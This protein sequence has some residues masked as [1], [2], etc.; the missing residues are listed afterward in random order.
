MRSNVK[1]ILKVLIFLI[2]LGSVV[3]LSSKEDIS[4]KGAQEGVKMLKLNIDPNYFDNSEIWSGSVSGDGW[5]SA[6]I[7]EGS[8]SAPTKEIAL[9]SDRYRQE[10]SGLGPIRGNDEIYIMEDGMGEETFTEQI[11]TYG[12]LARRFLPHDLVESVEEFD[13]DND[14]MDEQIIGICGLWG[15][16]CPHKILIVRNDS[17]IFETSARKI[18]RTPSGNGFTLV[19]QKEYKNP[20]GDMRTRFVFE[21]GKFMPVYEQEVKYFYT[22]KE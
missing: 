16:G 13:V 20:Y 18:I 1:L 6:T 15:N 7:I 2:I 8:R 22:E 19:W 17:V 5:S 4:E 21:G 14:G 11:D 10:V 3:L 9:G 12:D